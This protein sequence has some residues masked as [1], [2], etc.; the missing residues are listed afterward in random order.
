[1]QSAQFILSKEASGHAGLIGEQEYQISGFL[2]A[3]PCNLRGAI[4]CP[5]NTPKNCGIP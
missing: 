1:M 3:L 2:E 4:E 5:R